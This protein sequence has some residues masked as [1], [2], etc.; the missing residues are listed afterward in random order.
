[1]NDAKFKDAKN[2]DQREKNYTL[3][4][5]E[6]CSV[7]SRVKRR[8]NFGSAIEVIHVSGDQTGADRYS[9]S[10]FSSFLQRGTTYEVQLEARNAEGWG[11]LAR[12]FVTVDV[13]GVSEVK[14]SYLGEGVVFEEYL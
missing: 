2:Y 7:T 6:T 8:N 14:F 9:N 13:P 12:K 11:S 3:S 4:T 1:M 10:L 5:L